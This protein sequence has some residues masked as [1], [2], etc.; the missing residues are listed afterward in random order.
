MLH[1]T[2]LLIAFCNTLFGYDGEVRPDSFYFEN[3]FQI[4]MHEISPQHFNTRDY[5][6]FGKSTLL[7]SSY[8]MGETLY[9]VVTGVVGVNGVQVALISKATKDNMVCLIAHRNLVQIEIDTLKSQIHDIF[10]SSIPLDFVL[11]DDVLKVVE[12]NAVTPDRKTEPLMFEVMPRQSIGQDKRYE[13]TRSI[14][15]KTKMALNAPLQECMEAKSCGLHHLAVSSYRSTRDPLPHEKTASTPTHRHDNTP[16]SLWQSAL[17]TAVTF[18]DKHPRPAEMCDYSHIDFQCL[19]SNCTYTDSAFRMTI[20]RPVFNTHLTSTDT[21]IRPTE[22]DRACLAHLL[23]VVMFV[24]DVEYIGLAAATTHANMY[25]SA[26]IQSGATNGGNIFTD[27]GLNG[28]GVVVGVA[29]TGLDMHSCFFR[30]PPDERP[31]SSSLNTYS[32]HT[33]HTKRK[34]VQYVTIADD[35]DGTDGHG[36]HVVGTLAGNVLPSDE[37]S[38]Y[39]G[40]AV[41]AQVAMFDCARAS[42]NFLWIPSLDKE[43]FPAAAAAGGTLHSNSWTNN[44]YRY[45]AHTL[46][47]DAYLYNHPHFLALFA[48]GNRGPALGTISAPSIAKN[49]VGVGATGTGT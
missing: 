5:S 9:S 1:A 13:N 19:A 47:T 22:L 12:F 3:V 36:T 35:T 25:S 27:I 10:I 26:L 16:T 30:G 18:H 6:K 40:V 21:D 15:A 28:S 14:M 32:P 11:L 37:N 49:A 31:V 2:I 41:G 20:S 29:D 39:D 45:D 24:D 48:V 23:S 33:D 42:W 46:Q 7:C 44:I 43:V 8:D 38:A 17:Q 34:V 4:K